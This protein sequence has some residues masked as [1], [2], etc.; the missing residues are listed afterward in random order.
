VLKIGCADSSVLC[1]WRGG[2]LYKADV[3]WTLNADDDN[4]E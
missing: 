4:Y 3:K 1:T 2:Y